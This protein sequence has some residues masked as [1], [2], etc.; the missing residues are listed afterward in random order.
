VV[1]LGSLELL[2]LEAAV[3]VEVAVVESADPAGVAVVLVMLWEAGAFSPERS[4]E[5]CPRNPTPPGASFV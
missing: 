1:V 2:E 5:R 3:D 4:R